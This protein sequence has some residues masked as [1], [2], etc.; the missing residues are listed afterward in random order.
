MSIQ[1]FRERGSLPVS[2]PPRVV[3]L[4]L[5]LLIEPLHPLELTLQSLVLALQLRMLASHEIALTLGALSTF[6]EGI[7]VVR[8]GIVVSCRRLRHAAFMADSRQKYKYGILDLPGE[9]PRA[10]RTR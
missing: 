8:E 1:R 5:Q 6:A 9:G 2:G 3:Q 10:V 4:P 7:G